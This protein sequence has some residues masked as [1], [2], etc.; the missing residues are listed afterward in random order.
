MG[1]AY[2]GLAKVSKA[3]QSVE[4]VSAKLQEAVFNLICRLRRGTWALIPYL[5]QEV[6]PVIRDVHIAA[7]KT[8][9]SAHPLLE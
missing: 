9:P 1:M 4:L 6:L 7:H 5:I 3:C 2:F 8:Q